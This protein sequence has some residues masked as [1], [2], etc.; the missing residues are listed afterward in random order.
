MFEST[1]IVF[2]GG[3]V[4]ARLSSVLTIALFNRHAARGTICGNAE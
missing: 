3:V 4:L 2:H 1:S